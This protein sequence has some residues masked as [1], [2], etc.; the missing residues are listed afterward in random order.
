MWMIRRPNGTIYSRN[1]LAGLKA[2]YGGTK[3][4]LEAQ[5]WIFVDLSPTTKKEKPDANQ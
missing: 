4:E 3:K 2:A 5:G 1:T